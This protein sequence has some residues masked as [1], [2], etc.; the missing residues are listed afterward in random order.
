MSQLVRI[1]GM[2]TQNIYRSI[3][4][5]N[6]LTCPSYVWG[7]LGI[8]RLTHEHGRVELSNFDS[9]ISAYYDRPTP[10]NTHIPSTCDQG[11]GLRWDELRFIILKK[12]KQVPHLG[13]YGDRQMACRRRKHNPYWSGRYLFET[14]PD[15]R[16][17]SNRYLPVFLPVAADRVGW[18]PVVRFCFS[19][20]SIIFWIAVVSYLSQDWTKSLLPQ[21]F[22]KVAM[23]ISFSWFDAIDKSS[24]RPK[25][26]QSG[27]PLKILGYNSSN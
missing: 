5:D 9:N 15:F 1:L 25:N 11:D 22:I 10:T 24:K 20:M 14:K 8:E 6:S 4:F 21:L 19:D 13:I 12:S 7:F 26:L 17:V 27:L 23:R 16:F 3:V 2:K 18:L